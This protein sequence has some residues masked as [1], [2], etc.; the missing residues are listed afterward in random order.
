MATSK[1]SHS[2]ISRR[3]DQYERLSNTHSY[4]P[5]RGNNSRQSGQQVTGRQSQSWSHGR[6]SHHRPEN[7]NDML[8]GDRIEEARLQSMHIPIHAAAY[9]GNVERLEAL[10]NTG[11][12]INFQASR[13]KYK[14]TPLMIA[15]SRGLLEVVRL[16]IQ[17]GAKI[18]QLGIWFIS[19]Y[20]N[21]V[22]S[23]LLIF[24]LIQKS[25]IYARG[26]N[27]YCSDRWVNSMYSEAV[28]NIYYCLTVISTKCNNV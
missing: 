7:Q 20:S 4:L 25:S 14:V 28:N 24:Y 22:G 16:L 15:A 12:N 5:N 19:F 26:N 3:V 11:V 1:P 18:D 23:F 9:E 17:K 8:S 27:S 10:I 2:Q 6:L 13:H 21:L